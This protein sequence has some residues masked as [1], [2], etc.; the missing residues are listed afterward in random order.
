MYL[1]YSVSLHIQM[2]A[3]YLSVFNV[4]AVVLLLHDTFK[5]YTHTYAVGDSID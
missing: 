1:T 3:C 5:L 2:C 4:V